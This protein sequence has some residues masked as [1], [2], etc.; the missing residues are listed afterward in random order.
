MFRIFLTKKRNA[1]KFNDDE[2]VK[3][4]VQLKSRGNISLQFGRYLT[5]AD[6]DEMRKKVLK[7]NF[8]NQHE[9]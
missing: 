6:I 5:A 4:I 1:T 7:H 3:R 8:V 9:L 2:L